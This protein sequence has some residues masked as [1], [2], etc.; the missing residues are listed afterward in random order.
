MA[1]TVYFGLISLADSLSL[2][3]LI[4]DDARL[5]VVWL[6]RFSNP[7]LFPNDLIANYLESI[8]PIGYKSFYWAMN[9][10]GVEPLVIAKFLPLFLGLIAS[11]YGFGTALQLFPVP[12]SAFLSTLILNQ[13]WWLNDDLISATSRAFLYPIFL[14]FLY[15]LLK[16]SLVP[17]LIAI[18]LQALFY[19]QMALLQIAILT[20]RLWRWHKGQLRLVGDRQA[21]ILGSLSL[22]IALFALWPFA[23]QAAEFGPI[24]TAAQAKLMPEYGVDGRAQFFIP[25][26][27]AFWFVGDSGI[28]LPLHPPVIWAGAFLPFL[29]RY[30][31]ALVRQ[32]S[33]QIK[34]LVQVLIASVGLFGL[35]HVVFL[36]LHFPGRYM[37]YSLRIVMALAAGITLVLLA[38]IGLRWL[39]QMRRSRTA[40]NLWQ[41]GCLGLVAILAIASLVVPAVPSI[42]LS[43]HLQVKG[44]VPEVY[45]FLAQQPKDT[46]IASLAEEASNLPAFAKRSILVAREF[47]FPYHLGYYKQIRQR[48]IDLMQAHY[49]PELQDVQRFIAK[50]GVDFFLIEQD[51][52]TPA[53]LTPGPRWQRWLH[54]YQPVAS[55]AIARLQQGQTP[56]LAQF[57]DQCSVLQTKQFTVLTAACLMGVQPG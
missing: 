28:R 39:V 8:A 42:F 49:S 44:R 51:A 43:T 33:S 36:K 15:Y 48:A 6:E 11:V 20:V 45:E 25:N 16:R 29:L 14:A 19:P 26:L 2:P 31:S 21:W 1:A 50:Y 17:C 13:S 35:A 22:I 7:N 4:Q 54:Q 56:A 52:F 10:L 38:E 57:M 37:E 34:L 30:P 9:Q 23:Q 5:H 27:L 3:Y 53:Y 41:R 40:L 47:A 18:A 32:V 12:I 55:E 24:V 46:L